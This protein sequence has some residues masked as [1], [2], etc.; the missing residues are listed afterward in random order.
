M[1]KIPILIVLLLVMM[2]TLAQKKN[3]DVFIEHPAMDKVDK[4]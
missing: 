2:T 4:L 3:G 1:K